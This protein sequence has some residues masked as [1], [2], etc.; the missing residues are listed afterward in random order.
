MLIS[1]LLAAVLACQTAQAAYVTVTVDGQ[2][3]PGEVLAREGVT[4]VPLIRLLDAMGGWEAEWNQKERT[5]SA[6]TGLFSLS[7]TERR[8]H[9]LANGYAFDTGADVFL[10]SGRTYVPLRSVANL[11]GAEV[12]FVNWSTPIAVS[13]VPALKYTEEDL[14][15]LSRIISAESRG[16]SL[17]GQL[18][19]GHVVL[20]RVASSQFPNTIKEV[21]FDT[22][23][24]VQFEPVANG[25]IYDEPTAQSV[26]AA[27]MVLNGTRVIGDCMYFFSPAL[28][29]GT[30][31]RENC[32]YFTTI[33]CHRFYR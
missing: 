8:S 2:E 16:E 21:V 27:Q 5:A 30:W 12:E 13:T 31:I 24:A 9:V 33:G 19:V 23:D 3:L 32:T 18:A 20:N 10:Y 17:L 28:S 29:Q 14:Y 26:L 1:L 11:L 25:T 4:Y 6:D 22:K 7:V 15:W